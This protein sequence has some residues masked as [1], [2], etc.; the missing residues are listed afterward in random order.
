[1]SNPIK[2]IVGSHKQNNLGLG[3]ITDATLLSKFNEFKKTLNGNPKDIVMK[4]L[5]DGKI[6]EAQLE[7]AKSLAS[8][9]GGLLK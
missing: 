1:M 4:M 8:R 9:L 7:Q 2:Q 5:H 3:G 6:T